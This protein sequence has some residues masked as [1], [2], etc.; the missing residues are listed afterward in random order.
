MTYN[1]FGDRCTPEP[2]SK[3]T[4]TP[5]STRSVVYSSEPG[6]RLPPIV[7]DGELRQSKASPSKKASRKHEQELTPVDPGDVSVNYLLRVAIELIFGRPYRYLM[8]LRTSF[9]RNL[10][11]PPLSIK[12]RRQL[13][14]TRDLLSLPVKYR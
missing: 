11:H 7:D 9:G 2:I 6:E 8:T 14:P 5:N 13:Y 10:S 4:S 3:D 1:V 12:I